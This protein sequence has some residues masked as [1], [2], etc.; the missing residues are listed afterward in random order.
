MASR[1]RRAP[2]SWSGTGNPTSR[3]VRG[4]ILTRSLE[5]ARANARMVD[6]PAERAAA[7]TTRR[8]FQVVFPASLTI[9]ATYRAAYAPKALSHH[10]PSAKNAIHDGGSADLK[11]Y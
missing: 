4:V 6:S 8:F 10:E 7:A 1:W 3:S 5:R 2:K 11:K 9:S